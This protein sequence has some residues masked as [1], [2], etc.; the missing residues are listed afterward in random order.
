MDCSRAKTKDPDEWLE[1]APAF[2]QPFA[3]QLRDWMHRWEP[4]LMESIKWRVLCFTGRKLVCGLSASQRHLTETLRA[5]AAGRQWL[6][7]KL[8]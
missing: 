5:L 1:L 4:D 3:A 7:W 8:A 6:D 2:S